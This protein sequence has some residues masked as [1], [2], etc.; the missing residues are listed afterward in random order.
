MTSSLFWRGRATSEICFD[1]FNTVLSDGR[2]ADVPAIVQVHAYLLCLHNGS[3]QKVRRT[4]RLVYGNAS[5]VA[6]SPVSP[7]RL[8]PRKILLNVVI[9][10]GRALDSP[11]VI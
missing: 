10:K 2:L 4:A 9:I 5:A 7:R 6:V 11:D 1:R 3:D 8:R